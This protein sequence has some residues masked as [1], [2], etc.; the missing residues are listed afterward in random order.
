MSRMLIVRGLPGSGKSTYVHKNYPG[1]FLLETD[2]FNMVNGQ[3]QWTRERSRVAIDLITD[4]SVQLMRSANTPD[5]VLTG[6][7]CKYNSIE[8]HIFNALKNN[9]DIYIKT[10]T[11]DYGNI[12]NVPKST[13][14]M[15]K[16]NFENEKDFNLNAEFNISKFNMAM[17]K[18]YGLE[19]K[20]KVYFTDMPNLNWIF[21]SEPDKDDS[22]NGE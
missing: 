12:H 18:D 8:K 11:T 1:L 16:N 20:S 7:F 9:Y 3:Y 19:S 17:K 2:M 13:I 5:F 4:I 15:F 6:V 21:N 22:Y 10:L 14:E